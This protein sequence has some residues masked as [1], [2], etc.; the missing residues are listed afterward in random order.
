[1]EERL[2]VLVTDDEEL[3]RRKVCLMLG[4]RFRVDQ[5]RT[6]A[7]ARD[8]ARRGYDAILL[9]IV[10][11]DGNGIRLCREFKES[12][13]HCTVVISSSMESVEAWNKAFD[14]SADG[15]IEKREL[16]GLDPR[17]IELMIRN[18]VE[19]NRL[20]REAEQ[21]NRSQAKLLSVLT[22]DVRAPFQALIGTID[23][24]KKSDI[25][26][27]AATKVQALDQC[28]RDQL[29][30]INS[31]LEF[32]RLES[33]MAGMRRCP[34][35]VNLPV[36]QSLQAMKVLAQA[37]GIRLE[38]RLGTDLPTFEGDIGRICRLMNNLVSNA[39]KF[40]PRGGRIT[41]AAR[42]AH[43]HG[44]RGVEI[45]VTDTGVGIGPEDREKIFQPFHRGHDSG[46]EGER[47][48]GL[49]L[50][51]CREIVHLHGGSLDVASVEPKGTEFTAWFPAGASE[52]GQTASVQCEP[53]VYARPAVHA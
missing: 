48:A 21:R 42:A 23:L 37:K 19:R 29:A 39:V 35:D 38:S 15:Y 14:A 30:F 40:T 32:L 12:D 4:D 47:G 28:A 50:S 3:I 45:V 17:K 2:S 49:G 26:E 20:R 41:V 33:G 22:H 51:I 52:T 53:S 27:D 1:M 7:E 11:P 18:L 6:A 43:R 10:L 16:L 9:D 5:A 34:V 46:T 36:N 31:L 13:P 24:L 25:S 44:V 8:A